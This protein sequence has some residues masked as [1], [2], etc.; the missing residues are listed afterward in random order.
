MSQS[1]LFQTEQNF[2]LRHWQEQDTSFLTELGIDPLLETAGLKR[3]KEIDFLG[4]VGQVFHRFERS[5]RFDHSLAVARI[6]YQVGTRGGLGFTRLKQLT[7]AALLHD[8]GHAPFSHVTEPFFSKNLGRDHHHTLTLRML[9]EPSEISID[10]I[11]LQEAL[12]KC[13]ITPRD[14]SSVLA[15]DSRHPFSVFLRGVINV[16]RLDGMLRTATILGL[17]LGLAANAADSLVWVKSRLNLDTS[18]NPQLGAFWHLRERIYRDYIYSNANVCSEGV[19][20]RALEIA[21][22]NAGSS[23]SW[24]LD[25]DAQLLRTLASSSKAQ[26]LLSSLNERDRIAVLWRSK[27]VRGMPVSR[28]TLSKIDFDETRKRIANRLSVDPDYVIVFAKLFKNS[29]LRQTALP[30]TLQSFR[31]VIPVSSASGVFLSRSWMELV[32]VGPTPS[33]W[34]ST[35]PRFAWDDVF[36]FARYRTTNRLATLSEG[37]WN[38]EAT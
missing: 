34:F 27:T 14:V 15:K 9:R 13:S 11:P 25:T 17:P 36:S 37:G 4:T 30:L 28:E 10:G 1:T 12:S 16:D 2:P 32:V 20:N 21:A 5:S 22:S 24:A 18:Y 19:W 8:I 6:A 38:G 31:G 29:V 35:I 26:T 3:L 23:E 7:A 33:P